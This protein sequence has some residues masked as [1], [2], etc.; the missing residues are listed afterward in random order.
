ME[1]NKNCTYMRESLNLVFQ[2]LYHD[3]IMY[4]G[5]DLFGLSF[6]LLGV[7]LLPNN[8]V[9]G[10]LFL[11]IASC[12]WFQ[13]NLHINSYISM[14]GN[15]VMLLINFRT[16]VINLSKQKDLLQYTNFFKKIICQH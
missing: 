13:F 12:I 3:L 8:K 5:L 9:V 10:A 2:S 11:M 1:L 4:K 15:T 7:Y 14:F 6:M 16:F